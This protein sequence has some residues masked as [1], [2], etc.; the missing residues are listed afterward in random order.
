M[1]WVVAGSGARW[2]ADD[3]SGCG[4]RRGRHSRHSCTIGTAVV[5]REVARF[6]HGY[7]NHNRKFH[8]QSTCPKKVGMPSKNHQAALGQ[9]TRMQ[10]DNVV[11]DLI[12]FNTSISACAG[13]G[14]WQA[15]LSLLQWLQASLLRPVRACQKVFASI[16]GFPSLGVPYW[17]LSE[18][19]SYY[20]GDSIGGPYFRKP[21]YNV[22]DAAA[23]SVKGLF[24]GWR[25]YPRMR[26]R[27]VL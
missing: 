24:C 12:S 25:L 17:V 6:V 10:Q 3:T 22:A 1:V 4:G 11:P 15:A 7:P 20:L 13:S 9:H 14:N 2:C 19:K 26:C 18:G 27:F 8:V 5:V 16:L 23:F 21:P